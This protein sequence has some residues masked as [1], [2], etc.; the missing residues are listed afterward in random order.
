MR[1]PHP[2]SH[3]LGDQDIELGHASQQSSQHQLLTDQTS[4]ET[5]STDALSSYV[6]VLVAFVGL[7]MLVPLSIAS[8]GFDQT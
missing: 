1:A 3:D 2:G 6:L 7:F 8:I 5:E 4:E